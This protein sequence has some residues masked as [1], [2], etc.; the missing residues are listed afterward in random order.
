MMDILDIILDE[1]NV[2][3]IVLKDEKE[4]TY[5]FEQIAVI[6]YNQKIYCILK[7]ID[8]MH[9]VAEDEA[10]VFYVDESK[11]V[12]ILLVEKNE[13]AALKVFDEYYNL[14]EKRLNEEE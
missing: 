4:K 6:P 5:R 3:P 12:P 11:G 1:E 10:I 13:L 7:P 9:N 8:K 2:D 14:L